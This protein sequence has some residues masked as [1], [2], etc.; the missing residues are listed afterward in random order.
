[1]I[2]T[3]GPRQDFFNIVQAADEAGPKREAGR[4]KRLAFRPWRPPGFE[5]GPEEVVNQGLERPLASLQ[6]PLQP[7]THII[8]QRQGCPHIMMLSK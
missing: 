3:F 7:G 6:F 4:A 1:M 2:L 8:V 5:A